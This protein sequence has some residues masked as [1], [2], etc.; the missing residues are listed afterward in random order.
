MNKWIH[1]SQWD[2]YDDWRGNCCSEYPSLCMN[3]RK[4]RRL[5][6]KWS[7]YL[8]EGLQFD[9]TGRLTGPRIVGTIRKPRKPR[10]G[11]KIFLRGKP[12][13]QE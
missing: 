1:N 10:K 7:V 5:L 8:P 13:V 12:G 2:I 4:F 6:K 9:L 11:N 3:H